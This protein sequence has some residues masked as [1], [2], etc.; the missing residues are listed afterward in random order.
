MIYFCSII[1]LLAFTFHTALTRAEF[2][3]THAPYQD[4]GYVKLAI[5]ISCLSDQWLSPIITSSHLVVFEIRI[6]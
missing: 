2:L 5:Y 3:H 6:T 4:E 1:Y